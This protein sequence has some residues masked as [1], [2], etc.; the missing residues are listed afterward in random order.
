VGEGEGLAF[1]TMPRIDGVRPDVPQDAEA[2]IMQCLAKE[3]GAR[4]ATAT[5]LADTLRRC[6]CL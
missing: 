4:W 2:A 1:M 3:P 6:A 5:E